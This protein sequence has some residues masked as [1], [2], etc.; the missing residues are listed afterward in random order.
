MIKKIYMHLLIGFILSAQS[1][2]TSDSTQKNIDEHLTQL[3]HQLE[4]YNT[5]KIKD[6][7]W[8]ANNDY[9]Y[10][11]PIKHMGLARI[12]SQL[13][14]HIHNKT[15][16]TTIVTDET[17]L[18]IKEGIFNVLLNSRCAADE[19]IKQGYN[20]IHGTGK[21]YEA[22]GNY[23]KSTQFNP[24]HNFATKV[25][26]HHDDNNLSIH[27]LIDI[28]EDSI[29]QTGAA[30]NTIKNEIEASSRKVDATLQSI[31]AYRTGTMKN[32]KKK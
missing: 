28:S 5:V 26:P 1:L 31:G 19:E 3:A 17:A 8:T 7:E 18:H 23:K 6:Y 30:W 13:Q 9:I 22:Y 29:E 2:F 16:L 20:F 14:T 10:T 25:W 21:F 32:S 11:P 27:Q 4:P 12:L 24:A 15:P